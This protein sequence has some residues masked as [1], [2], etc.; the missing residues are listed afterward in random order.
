MSL[1]T[2]QGQVGLKWY[3]LY[4]AQLLCFLILIV[5]WVILLISVPGG[6]PNV[7]RILVARRDDQLT[8]AQSKPPQNSGLN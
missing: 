3:G 4:Y 8:Q 5:L 6:P 7:L 1:Y 2:L